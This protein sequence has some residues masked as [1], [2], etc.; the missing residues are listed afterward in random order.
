MI[1]HVYKSHNENNKLRC[2]TYHNNEYKNTK[3][4]LATKVTKEI[5]IRSYS[6]T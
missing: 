4:S 2:N 3:N 6:L 1:P 5:Q